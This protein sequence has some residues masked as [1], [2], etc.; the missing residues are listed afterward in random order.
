MKKH[1][2]SLLM[3]CTVLFA[4][5]QA[6]AETISCDTTAD[7][8]IDQCLTCSPVGLGTNYNDKTRLTVS[9][10]PTKGLARGL[11]K[12]DIPACITA[13]QIQ[14]AVLYLSSSAHTG[15]GGAVN[16]SIHALNSPFAE[17][18]ETWN[19]HNGGDYDSSVTSSGSLPAG[20]DWKT[21]INVTALL[22]GKLHKVRNNGMLIKLAAE[23]PDKLYQHIASR[24]CDD[25]SNSDYVAADEPPRLAIVLKSDSDSDGDGVLDSVDNCPNKCNSQQ[26]DSDHDGYGDV[27]DPDPG[28]T[29][30]P[31]CGGCGGPPCCEVEC[32]VPDSDSDGT[33]NCADNCP[34]VCNAQQLD[35]D[36]DG[37][38]DV[39]DTT[40]GCGGCGGPACEQ[41]CS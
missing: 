30:P 40:P 22:V 20:N 36:G 29:P 37:I 35:A 7:V 6:A 10:H 5:H 9:Y 39:C 8:Y 2:L 13:S 38:G 24:E 17:N 32:S 11:L 31:N 28:C 3:L 18:A 33:P 19:T 14:S 16:I 12:V 25:T 27:C 23:G 21:T 4:A 15:G 41:Q 1:I 34:S 26:L